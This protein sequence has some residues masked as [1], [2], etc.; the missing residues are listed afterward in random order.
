VSGASVSDQ[1]GKTAEPA[2]DD[3]TF[4]AAW[5]ALDAVLDPELDESVASLGFV[6]DLSVEN[7]TVHV[8]F[9]LPTAW[10][11]LN[12][13]W[14]MAEDMRDALLAVD[15]IGR[16]DIRLIDHFAAGRINAGIASGRDFADVFGAEAGG[17]L[18]ALRTTFRRKAFLGRMAILIGLMRKSGR[19]DPD[20]VA[21]TMSDL[22][23][24]RDDP[25]LS[26]AVDRYRELRA[27]FGGPADANDA[28]FRTAGGE[29]IAPDRLTDFL[30]DI[31]MTRRGVEANG[32]MCR[33]MLKA[34]Y[35]DKGKTG[36]AS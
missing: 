33:V 8:T 18:S 6:G 5:K 22:A 23:V 9:R 26:D 17:S 15:G 32:E 13:A 30:R 29:P 36:A 25:A 31:R 14:I 2:A 27:I 28:A 24:L 19:S 16:T 12:F 7:D 10:C 34:R 20:I 1:A 21:L 4:A 35:G 11:S 3:A